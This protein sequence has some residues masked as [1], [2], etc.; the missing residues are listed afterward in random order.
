MNKLVTEQ[1]NKIG[2]KNEE[3]GKPKAGLTSSEIDS[4]EAK[5]AVVG[6]KNELEAKNEVATLPSNPEEE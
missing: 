4:I 5:K 1:K 6:Q 3:A 2:E